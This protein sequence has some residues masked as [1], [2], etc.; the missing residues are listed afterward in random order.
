MKTPTLLLTLLVAAG[1]GLALWLTRENANL[2]TEIAR[3]REAPPPPRP[4]EEPAPARPVVESAP[5]SAHAPTPAAA[6]L[7]DGGGR[8][9]FDLKKRW[10]DPAWRAQRFNE[11]ILRVE[12]KYGRLFQRLG[13]LPPEKLEALKRQLAEGELTMAEA[14]LPDKLPVDETEGVARRQ[15]MQQAAAENDRQL[16]ALLDD[17]GYANYEAFEKSQAYREAVSPLANAM[18]SSGV[19]VDEA[20]EE[21]MLDAY[22]TAFRNASARAAS[23]DPTGLDEAGRAALKKSQMEALHLELMRQFSGVLNETQLNAFM[24]AQLES[25]QLP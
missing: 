11:A 23:A 7:S 9:L 13:P 6:P 19:A 8:A 14:A 5:P 2:R 17:A 15:A 21:R 20:L 1:G 24:Q 3:L 16:Q 10:R 4:V 22:A 12:R 18:R 25:E